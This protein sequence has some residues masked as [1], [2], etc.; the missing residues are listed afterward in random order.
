MFR[1]LFIHKLPGEIVSFPQMENFSLI[2][3]D[4][5]IQSDKF[6]YF[7]LGEIQ[8]KSKTDNLLFDFRCKI[9]YNDKI[10][11]LLLIR[12]CFK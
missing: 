2:N 5:K 10:D 8:I 9:L 1:A 11:I 7:M 12:K 6:V 3:L 4:K